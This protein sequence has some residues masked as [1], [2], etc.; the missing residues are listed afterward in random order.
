MPED[1]YESKLEELLNIYGRLYF[2]MDGFWYI[3]VMNRFGNDIAMEL[4]LWVW[5]KMVKYEMDRLSKALSIEGNSVAAA[6]QGLAAS[7]WFRVAEHVVDLHSN[8]RA[9]LTVTRCPTLEA[10]EK[11]GAGR[12]STHCREV[13][14]AIFQMYADYFNPAIKVRGLSLPPRKEKEGFCCKWEFKLD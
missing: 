14:S 10:L 8:D 13:D 12:E 2:A 11:E 9:V 7:P 4:D 6:V 1:N 5:R 3:A